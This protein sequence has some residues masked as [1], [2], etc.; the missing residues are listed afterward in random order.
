M[1]RPTQDLFGAPR[2]RGAVRK[3]PP[4]LLPTD[5]HR[6]FPPL[7]SAR[8]TKGKIAGPAAEFIH[9]TSNVKWRKKE[10][11]MSNFFSNFPAEL[12]VPQFSIV[13]LPVRGCR[14][15]RHRVK[16]GLQCSYSSR[17]TRDFSTRPRTG[18]LRQFSDDCRPHCV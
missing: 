8:R 13:P 12:L 1:V 17:L 3:L 10:K 15:G 9:F 11:E 16:T 4:P 18:R 7:R 14:L 6:R 5:L 2:R